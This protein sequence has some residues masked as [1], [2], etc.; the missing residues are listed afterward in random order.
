MVHRGGSS[1][2]GGIKQGYKRRRIKGDLE[3]GVERSR[4]MSKLIIRS[5]TREQRVVMV[6]VLLSIPMSDHYIYTRLITAAEIIHQLQT[7]Y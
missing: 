1:Q 5:E 4:Y 2:A 3:A 6:H 7:L